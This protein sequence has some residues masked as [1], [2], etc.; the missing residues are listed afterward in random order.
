MSC[1]TFRATR[2][3]NLYCFQNNKIEL[4]MSNRRKNVCCKARSIDIK[5]VHECIVGILLCCS[6]YTGDRTPDLI[7]NEDCKIM[8]MCI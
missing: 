2:S 6:I 8:K 7:K 4:I 3:L 1:A 5:H